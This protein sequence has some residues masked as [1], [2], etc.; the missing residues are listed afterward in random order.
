MAER[1]T[2]EEAETEELLT[3]LRIQ[4]Y[5][6]QQSSKDVCRHLT[7]YKKQKHA[8]EVMLQFGRDAKVCDFSLYDSRVSRRQFAIEAFRPFNSS[9]LAFEIKNLSKK[10]KMAVN[11]LELDYLNKVDLPDK[12][13]VRFSEFQLMFFT[14][15]GDSNQG[16]DILFEQAPGPLCQEVG[17]A[18]Y[19]VPVTDTGFDYVAPVRQFSLQ[20]PL[21]NDER[22]LL[23]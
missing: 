9:E 11:G 16:F 7:L 10:G 12:A 21:E 5:H 15:P 14:E 8:L 17:D 20:G 3:C 1:K 4:I 13:L 19:P 22:M 2:F 6:P 23:T 18:E